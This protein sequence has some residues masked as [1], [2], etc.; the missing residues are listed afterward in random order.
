M[1]DNRYSLRLNHRADINIVF[2]SGEAIKAQTWNISDGGLFIECPD[3]PTLKKGELAEI[4]VLG[5][6]EAIPRPVK[7][8][9]IDSKGG[10]AVRFSMT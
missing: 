1:K 8:T 5:I 2:A 3:H 7:I 10:I 4:I 9:R 6:Q